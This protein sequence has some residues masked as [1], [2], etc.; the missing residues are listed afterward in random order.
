MEIIIDEFHYPTHRSFLSRIKRFLRAIKE[1]S[2]IFL[3]LGVIYLIFSRFSQHIHPF[4]LNKLL[5]RKL[6]QSPKKSLGKKQENEELAK[7]LE[8]FELILAEAPNSGKYIE[9]FNN[10]RREIINMFDFESL[11]ENLIQSHH[12]IDQRMAVLDLYKCELFTYNCLWFFAKHMLELLFHIKTLLEWKYLEK[13]KRKY[14]NAVSEVDKM[15]DFIINEF[16]DN[17]IHAGMNNLMNHIKKNINMVLLPYKSGLEYEFSMI[18]ELFQALESKMLCFNTKD[19]KLPDDNKRWSSCCLSS[20][21]QVKN[22][23]QNKKITFTDFNVVSTEILEIEEEDQEHGVNRPKNEPTILFPQ[24]QGLSVPKN[25][26][27]LLTIFMGD[28]A[29]HKYFL[30]QEYIERYI[31]MADKDARAERYHC[32]LD[33]IREEDE[34]EGSEGIQFSNSNEE[35]EIIEEEYEIDEIDEGEDFEEKTSQTIEEARYYFALILKMFCG[36]IVDFLESS[37]LNI[38]MFYALKYEFFQWKMRLSDN[39]NLNTGKIKDL[40]VWLNELYEDNI[41]EEEKKEGDEEGGQEKVKKIEILLKDTREQIYKSLF[42]NTNEYQEAVNG[43]K[44]KKGGSKFNKRKILEYLIT[45]GVGQ[46]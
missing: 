4:W 19:L 27:D 6:A 29:N 5:G 31:I 33:E 18:I 11:R 15:T 9:F 46:K 35:I 42:L 23:P 40:E 41:G 21:Q 12:L 1:K 8:A 10:H 34:G 17:L 14:H 26:L 25:R 28:I 22:K 44:W 20:F 43:R 16:Y 24:K 45:F 39:M 30:D 13:F 7:K 3:I 32:Y 38:Y 36:E 37:N 2:Y